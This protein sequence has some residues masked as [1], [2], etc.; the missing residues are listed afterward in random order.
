[1][2][3]GFWGHLIIALAVTIVTGLGVVVWWLMRQR[4]SMTDGVVAELR[5][6]LEKI[7]NQVS[8]STE[9]ME[10]NFKS[11]FANLE[12]RFTDECREME[13]RFSAGLK[14]SDNK[15]QA[16]A[17]RI[18]EVSEALLRVRIEVLEKFMPTE[19]IEAAHAEIKASIK[20]AVIRV[21]GQL[22]KMLEKL[23]NIRH[24]GA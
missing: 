15:N 3:D 2:L 11:D 21:E 19:R 6:S 13:H 23:D 12:K 22:E 8:A 9:R 17:A 10:A 5:A 18:S 7:A 4:V 16:N 20:E 1:M 24:Q 14:E